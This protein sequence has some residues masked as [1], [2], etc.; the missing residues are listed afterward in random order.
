M[1]DEDVEL[2]D[3]EY[4]DE[5]K[6]CAA[7]PVYFIRNYIWIVH[8]IR[9]RVP[10]DL[11]GFQ[12]RIVENVTGNRFSIMRKFRQAGATTICAAYAL[13]FIIFK[14]DKNVIVLSI[15]ERESMDFLSR[16]LDMYDNLPLFLKPNTVK[17]TDHLLKLSTGSRV[18]ALPGRAGR[19]EAVSLLIVDE[20]AFVEKLTDSWK[21]IFP[22]ISTGGQAL[23]IS[24]V[25]GMGNLYY[26]LYR[27]AALG[28]NDFFV[29]DIHW[30]EHPDYTEEWAKMT[31]RNVGER[32]WMQEYEGEFLGTGETF[33]DGGSLTRIKE[34][35]SENYHTKYYNTMRVFEEPKPYY[36]YIL[37]ADASYGRERDY[38]A[39][40]II[41]AYNGNQVAEFYTNTMSVSDFA[42]VIATEAARYNSA[43]VCPER[44]G[45]GL[46]LMKILFEDLEYENMWLDEKG[47]MGIQIGSKN[48]ETLLTLLQEQLKYSKINIFSDR[49]FMELAT[50][51]ISENGKLEAEAGF[52]DDLV[53]SLAL[54]SFVKNEVAGN[55]P[56][57]ILTDDNHQQSQHDLYIGSSHAGKYNDEEFRE[58]L[59]W[60]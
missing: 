19:G 26:E 14:K 8:P 44:N 32:A 15:G 17:R 47:E 50:F 49:T 55:S 22:T 59:K 40:H 7:D 25:N 46:V 35:L 43:Y 29:I 18:R 60:V 54:A 10:F 45:L 30:R 36:T 52:H 24:T 28:K 38:S 37:G 6:K 12:K 11:F 5:F 1:F 34:S 13:W 16:V 31:R 58:Y 53:M 51:I 56:I 33:I 39:F 57:P 27:D 48:K 9:G 20:A 3:A 42:K 4:R 23:I 41:N 2:S 21:A